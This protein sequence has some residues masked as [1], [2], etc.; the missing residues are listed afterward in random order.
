MALGREFAAKDVSAELVDGEGSR[1]D[2]Q[3][4]DRDEKQETASAH[5]TRRLGEGPPGGNRCR[6]GLQ[7]EEP[8][9]EAVA[10]HLV[11]FA[12]VRVTARR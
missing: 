7:R 8:R 4:E 5:W 6:V 10:E 12:S 3:R 2:E 9:K 11:D 1:D